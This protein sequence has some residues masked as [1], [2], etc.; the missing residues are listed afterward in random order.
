MRESEVFRTFQ[1]RK[2]TLHSQ[3]SVRLSVSHRNPSA[4]WNHHPSSFILQ[5]SSFFI[6]PSFI[7]QLLSFSTCLIIFVDFDLQ[8]G[9]KVSNKEICS[10]M[11]HGGRAAFAG[12]A[13]KILN[14]HC[15]VGGIIVLSCL[16]STDKYGIIKVQFIPSNCSMLEVCK[17]QI[18]PAAIGNLFNATETWQLIKDKQSPKLKQLHSVNK[19]L[20]LLQLLWYVRLASQFWFV[21]QFLSDFLISM[22]R[23]SLYKVIKIIDLFFIYLYSNT[24]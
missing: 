9:C 21:N 12:N 6:H 2:R 1:S 13:K 7:L 20:K 16:V 24:S 15:T 18:I 8:A 19:C 4:A 10:I 3:M 11:N 5:H 17:W 23:R 22:F 14:F